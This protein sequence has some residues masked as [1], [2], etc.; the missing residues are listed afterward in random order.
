MAITYSNFASSGSV[1]IEVEGGTAYTDYGSEFVK[2]LQSIVTSL[3]SS[4]AGMSKEERPDE[5]SVTC[6]LLA[7][8]SGGFAIS[9][10]TEK[11]N[12]QVHFKWGK[13]N[14]QG[15]PGL[16]LLPKNLTTGPESL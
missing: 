5:V 4:I 15:L 16:D 6:G 10:G 12:F 3:T 13:A 9:L 7:I 14:E 1:R 8:P 11:A 2:A